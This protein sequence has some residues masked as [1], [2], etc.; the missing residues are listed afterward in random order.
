MDGAETTIPTTTLRLHALGRV[1]TPRA[2]REA[3]LDEFERSG[4]SAARFARAAG[5]KYQTFV[6]WV[7]GRRHAHGDY[8]RRPLCEPATI[9]LAEVEEKSLALGAAGE[10]LGCG[11]F[12]PGYTVI[13]RW[14]SLT[15]AAL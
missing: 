10:A 3:M 12:R 9:W 7:Q 4:L 5:I 2:Q 11:R 14:R 1:C 6:T 13:P 8:E 15:A